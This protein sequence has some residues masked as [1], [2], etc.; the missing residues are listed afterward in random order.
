LIDLISWPGDV[1]APILAGAASGS[2]AG[3]FLLAGGS[4][5]RR[6]Q[7]DNFRVMLQVTQV[8][9]ELEMT[10][11]IMY[12]VDLLHAEAIGL[13]MAELAHRSP[14]FE[15]AAEDLARRHEGLQRL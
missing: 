4:R 2:V 14:S 6:L 8:Q 7:A 12:Q 10:R 9:A 11:R 15:R 13:L 3:A 5:V 1:W